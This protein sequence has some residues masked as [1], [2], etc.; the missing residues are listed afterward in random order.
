MRTHSTRRGFTLVEIMVVIVILGGLAAIVGP[1]IYDSLIRADIKRAEA[2]MA[3]FGNAIKGYFIEHRR[4]PTCLEDLTKVDPATG[5]AP[6][7]T[8]PLDPWG[9]TYS[10]KPVGGGHVEIRSAGRDGEEGTEDDLVWPKDA[11]GD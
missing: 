2:Q 3:M 4:N 8:I 11:A 7:T 10:L 9:G 5:E 6:L 1:N